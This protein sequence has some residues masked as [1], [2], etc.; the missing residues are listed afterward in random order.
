MS[1]AQFP[2]L[3][4]PGPVPP[5]RLRR[6]ID[7]SVFGAASTA[8]LDA[9]H[10]LIGQDRALDAIA[11]G[12]AVRHRGFHIY[13]MGEP[14]SRRRTALR[15]VLEDRA[16]A[17]EP[18]PD[19]VYVNN[20]ADERRPKAL[21]LP[22]GMAVLLRDAMAG[23][24]EDLVIDLPAAFETEDYKARRGNIDAA[25]QARQQTLFEALAERA[26]NAGIAIIRTPTGFAFAPLRDGEVMKPEEV[27]KLSAEE[28]KE[29]EAKLRPL[30]EALAD[31]VQN[32]FP[33]IAREYRAAV[34][35]FDREVALQAIR[36]SIAEVAGQFAGIEPIEVY[37]RAVE[38]DL[39][40]NVGLFRALAEEAE[41]QPTEIKITHTHPALRRYRV[42]VM[43]GGPESAAGAGAP[44]VEETD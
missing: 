6:R 16:R 4:E 18:P 21:R 24:I 25:H 19:W 26:R 37:L 35:A 38:A 27:E 31:L 39:A 29:I 2:P 23:L 5:D 8:E 28:R 20:F 30:Q 12:A 44:L 33:A 43:T 36:R 41:K 13:V 15:S 42:N 10:G 9:H 17:A 14:G 34:R 11:F 3:P 1:E 22:H 40:E 32:R 7:P